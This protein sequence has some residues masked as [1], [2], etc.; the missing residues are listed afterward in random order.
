MKRIRPAAKRLA[1]CLC[2]ALFAFSLPLSALAAPPSRPENQYVLDSAGV[3][4]DAAE[5]EIISENQKLFRDT[6]AQIVIAAVDFLGGQEIDDYAYHLFNSW[7]VGSQERN[8]GLLLVMSIAED[9]YYAI[10]GYGVEDYFTGGKLQDILDEK[11]EPSFAEEDYSAAALGFF[12]EAL[13][14]ME[15]YY[16]EYEDGYGEEEF[17]T[18]GFNYGPDYDGDDYYDDYREPFFSSIIPRVFRMVAG[19]VIFIV[20]IIVIIAILR[21]FT[22]GGRGGPPS[23]GGGG[24]SFWTGILLG[25]MIGRNR[26]TRWSAPPPRGGFGG[27]MPRPPRSGG[28]GG[29]HGG[30]SGGGRSGG[31]GSGRSGGFTG[32]GGSR[33]GGAGRH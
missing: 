16:R 1:L 18:G 17:H 7:G 28:F 15:S 10:P 13:R 4:S 2:A 14:E 12:R 26:R 3:L 20:V 6:G 19:I 23:G 11:V 25:N 9:D 32:G 22:G 8:N 21:A 31:F 24:G 29:S 33:G 30:F 27:P 5:Q